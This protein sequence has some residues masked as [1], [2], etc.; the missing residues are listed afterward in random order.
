[1]HN[2]KQTSKNYL[3]TICLSLIILSLNLILA[4]EVENNQSSLAVSYKTI[5]TKNIAMAKNT[6]KAV[7]NGETSIL[8]NLKNMTIIPSSTETLVEEPQ[9]LV[10]QPKPQIITPTPVIKKP[11][12]RLPTEQGR[13]TTYPNPGHVAY[14]IT[15]GRG[16]AETIYPIA[17]GNISN[18]Y[19]DS[20]GALIVSVHHVIN[21]TNYTS[22]YVHLSSYA[23]NIYVG[24]PVTTDTPLGQ[25]GTTGNSTGVHLHISLTDCSLNDPNDYNCANLGKFFNYLTQRYYQGFQGINNV[26]GVP[27]VWYSR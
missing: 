8:T 13:V 12:W 1:M 2:K 18:I 9:K 16:T 22:L 25:M 27:N 17:D 14:D 11:T 19:K 4:S 21:G 24:M 15:S 3:I 6:I 23:P 5:N 7:D 26:M 20:A 10:E